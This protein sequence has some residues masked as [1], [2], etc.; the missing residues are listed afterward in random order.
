MSW[1]V[2]VIL[3]IAYSALWFW[4]GILYKGRKFRPIISVLKDSSLSKEDK[5]KKL[6]NIAT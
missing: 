2:W 4:F 3:I 1:Y 5:A 6:I